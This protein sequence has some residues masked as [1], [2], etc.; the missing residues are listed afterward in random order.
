MLTLRL[1]FGTMRKKYCS[2]LLHTNRK[3]KNI[4]S[5]NCTEKHSHFN[6]LKSSRLHKSILCRADQGSLASVSQ[7]N[8]IWQLI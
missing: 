3:K 1:T 6:L 5:D 2:I 8:D 4:F 7:L